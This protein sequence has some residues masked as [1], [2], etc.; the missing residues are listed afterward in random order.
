MNEA[1][2]LTDNQAKGGIRHFLSAFFLLYIAAIKLNYVRRF[3]KSDSITNLEEVDLSKTFRKCSYIILY[4]LLPPQ[5]YV[6]QIG[7][8]DD[9]SFPLLPESLVNPQATSDFR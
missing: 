5:A 3:V 9:Y 1:A 6:P 8:V 2:V 7:F 4:L